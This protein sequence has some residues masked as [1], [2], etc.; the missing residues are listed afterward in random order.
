MAHFHQRR[1]IRI[2][3]P[4]TEI[5]PKMGTVTIRETIHIGIQI[6]ICTGEKNSA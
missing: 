3:I 6:W 1:R 5:R 4:G 2:Q